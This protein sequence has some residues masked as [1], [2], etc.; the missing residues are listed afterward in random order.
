MA[1]GCGHWENPSKMSATGAD[2]DGAALKK[3]FPK[4]VEGLEVVDVFDK[5]YA[6]DF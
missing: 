6:N 5:L 3:I 4:L 2:V 1:F